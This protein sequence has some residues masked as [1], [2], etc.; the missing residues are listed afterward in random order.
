MEFNI[1]KTI[2]AFKNANAD[3][4]TMSACLLVQKGMSHLNDNR[5]AAR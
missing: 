4:G 5:M 1:K 3:R 2:E